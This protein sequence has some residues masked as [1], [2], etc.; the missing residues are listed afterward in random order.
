MIN[1]YRYS[2]AFF[3]LNLFWVILILGL[4][5]G[6]IALTIPIKVI[7]LKFISRIIQ[8]LSRIFL[9]LGNIRVQ[10][11]GL[12]TSPNEKY[13]EPLVI[14]SNHM[15]LLE[16]LV[17]AAYFRP[18][19]IA[20]VELSKIPI[21]NWVLKIAHVILVCRQSKKN[22]P[23]EIL[24][25]TERLNEGFSVAFFPEARATTGVRLER[26]RTPF[27][28]AATQTQVA[29]L[30]VTVNYVLLNGEP[31]GLH[32]KSKLLWLTDFSIVTIIK[33]LAMADE[34]LLELWTHRLLDPRSYSSHVELAQEAQELISLTFKPL[35]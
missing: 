8:V 32:N 1:C 4:I 35:R 30:P 12:D 20:A 28:Q 26:F 22:L 27:F 16:I 14:V 21:V 9:W 17:L 3:R 18:F 6:V 34:I 13:S 10:R 33:T 25:A 31:I 19:F 5:F 7:R 23:T 29:V 24:K 2:R 15:G 11:L